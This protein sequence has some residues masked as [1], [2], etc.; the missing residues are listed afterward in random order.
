MKKLVGFFVAVGLV[1]LLVV[2]SPLNSSATSSL[3]ESESE[4]VAFSKE[5]KVLIGYGLNETIRSTI[6]YNVGGWTGTLKK[7]RSQSTGDRILVEYEGTVYC[8]G[9]CRM[10]VD[11]DS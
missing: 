1:F 4:L 8:T 7:V 11:V 2:G 6:Y 5:V 10:D 3:P 9:T